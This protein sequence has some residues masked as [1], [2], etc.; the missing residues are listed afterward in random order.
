[1]VLGG[2]VKDTEDG[3]QR[4]GPLTLERLFDASRVF[5]ATH[6][7]ILVAGGP[8]GKG[9]RPIANL[10][11]EILIN[12]FG[13][14]V[15]CRETASLT[16]LENARFSAR[17]LVA[18]NIHTVLVITQRWHMVRALWAFRNSGTSAVPANVA[19]SRALLGAPEDFL[20]NPK[21]LLESFYAFHEMIGL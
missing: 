6:L 17:L 18:S 5:H 13:V 7:P 11:A 4:V 8:V 12:E 20:P 21:S 1:V 19:S 16:T 10:M 15:V 14:P 9:N 2:D 3:A